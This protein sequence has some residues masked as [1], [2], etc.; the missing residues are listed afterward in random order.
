MVVG[1]F[2]P[3]PAC[4]VVSLPYRVKQQAACNADHQAKYST[5]VVCH[6]RVIHRTSP[7]VILPE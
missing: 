2:L 7:M 3:P 5:D 4:L 6:L 1:M